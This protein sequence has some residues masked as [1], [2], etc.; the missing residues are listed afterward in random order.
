MNT[1]SITVLMPVYNCAR[2][3]NAAIE[4]IL[5]QTHRDFE[6]LIIDDASTDKSLAILEAYRDPRIRLVRNPVNLGLTRSLNIGLG[7]ATGEWIARQDGDDVS[8]PERLATQLAFLIKNTEAA[9][10]GSQ[11]RLVDEF[12]AS[13]GRR[14][15]PL[16]PISIRWASLFENPI[17]HSSV[18][19]R[20]RLIRDEFGGYDE[21]F[22]CCQ[23]YELWCRLMARYPIWNL[24]ERLVSLREH[25]ASVTSTK[26]EEAGRLVRLVVERDLQSAFPDRT[27]TTEDLRLLL[28]YRAHLAPDDVAP[29]HRLYSE[30]KAAF[31]ARFANSKEGD[32]FRQTVALQ[33]ARIGYNLLTR[34]RFLAISELTKAIRVWPPIALRQPWLRI[35][36]LAVLGDNARRLHEM[37]RQRQSPVRS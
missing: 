33:F 22:D 27:S 16:E 13:R 23:D 25:S 11:V 9:L 6:F 1:P 34:D 21:T 4:S 3:L 32:D 20:T 14:D 35:A 29:F 8:T 10:V 5:A 30:L 2:Y 7:L 15:S 18:M 31:L 28:Q 17:P 24:P 12:G 37:K 36:A 19:F 26:K